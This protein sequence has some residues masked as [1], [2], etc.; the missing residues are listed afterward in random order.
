MIRGSLQVR[1]AF[2]DERVADRYVD[3]RFREPLGALLHARQ[4]ACLTRVLKS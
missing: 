1:E 2:R 3:E 4:V